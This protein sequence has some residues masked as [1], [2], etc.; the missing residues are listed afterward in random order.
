MVN[1]VSRRLTGGGTNPPKFMLT[2]SQLL[3][4]FHRLVSMGTMPTTGGGSTAIVFLG[5]NIFRQ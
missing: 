4:G 5:N 1:A 3:E 2:P